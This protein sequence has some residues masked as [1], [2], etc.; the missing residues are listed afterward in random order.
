V[1]GRLVRRRVGNICEWLEVWLGAVFVFLF[2]FV[3]I[4]YC[5]AT[6]GRLRSGFCQLEVFRIRRTLFDTLGK[7]HQLVETHDFTSGVIS[8]RSS[9]IPSS[10][11]F[12]PESLSA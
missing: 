7:T 3:E 5:G 10:C 2:E 6:L 9:D 11:C 4:Y 8:P 1:D 12:A